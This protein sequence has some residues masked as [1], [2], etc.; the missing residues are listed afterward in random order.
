M[1]PFLPSLI[2]FLVPAFAVTTMA[3]VG[4]G[5]EP[6]KVLQPFR[7]P[8]MVGTALA[9]NFVVVPLL[10]LFLI[11][12]FNLHD[13]H[14]AGLLLVASAAG[15]P[16]TLSLVRVARGSRSMA[17]ALLILLLPATI[18]YLP[19]VTPRLL[20]EARVD[21]GAVARNLVLSM[22]L[23]LAAG[24]TLR[25]FRPIWAQRVF[26]V[27]HRLSPVLLVTLIASIV[28]ANLQGVRDIVT[29]PQTLA[30]AVLLVFGGVLAGYAL[31]VPTRRSRVVLALGTG[32]RNV[33]AATI[34]A[35]SFP[36]Q[37]PLTMVVSTSILGFAILFPSAWLLRR[38]GERL[39]R[40]RSAS[41]QQR[42]R[43]REPAPQEG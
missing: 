19:L 11:R 32:Q 21:S 43:S 42:V 3:S 13:G 23:P 28:A 17:G 35:A 26:P 33:A 20:P 41:S 25:W 37:I 34:V 30:A 36:T 27:L 4:I 9:A 14:A 38:G 6:R 22:L 39:R 7:R 24:A 29:E 18:L 5:A 12:S 1:D 8:V 31:G 10:A 15:A 40:K 2:A 16:F